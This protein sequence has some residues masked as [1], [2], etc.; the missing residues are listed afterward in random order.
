MKTY[1]EKKQCTCVAIFAVV[2]WV[3]KICL[4]LGSINSL[5]ENYSD[6][7]GKI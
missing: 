5:L 1:R 7:S 2:A 3:N 6:A 4:N